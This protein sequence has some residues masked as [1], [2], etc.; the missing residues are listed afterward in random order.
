LSRLFCSRLRSVA[1]VALRR[2]LGAWSSSMCACT[3]H[4][5]R[6][7]HDPPPSPPPSPWQRRRGDS[8]QHLC[9]R[10][11]GISPGRRPGAVRRRQPEAILAAPPAGMS[12]GHGIQTA[13]RGAWQM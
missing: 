10:A 1:C 5:W 6:P 9:A 7:M 2:G 12:C 11:R 8:D 13:A 3:R 4:L